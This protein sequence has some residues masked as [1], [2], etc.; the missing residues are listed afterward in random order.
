MINAVRSTVSVCT[1]SLR[2]DRTECLEDMSMG[3]HTGMCSCCVRNTY[4]ST[5]VHTSAY[6]ADYIVMISACQCSKYLKTFSGLQ[7]M[8]LHPTTRALATGLQ[9]DSLAGRQTD[10]QTDTLWHTHTQIH[11]LT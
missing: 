10:T 9:A 5:H 8:R 1:R 6:A 2:A 3:A 7:G 4:D 11:R